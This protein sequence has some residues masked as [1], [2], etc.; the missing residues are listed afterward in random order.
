[1][2]LKKE[3]AHIIKSF[4]K[5][6][7]NKKEFY[8]AEDMTQ[9]LECLPTVHEVSVHSSA[10][11]VTGHGGT[12]LGYQLLGGGGLSFRRSRSSS[13]IENLQGQPRIH[14]TMS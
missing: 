1:M 3:E 6:S 13:A 8:V 4:I 10:P 14:N 9:F 7:A 2:V 11:Y 5:N 12:C